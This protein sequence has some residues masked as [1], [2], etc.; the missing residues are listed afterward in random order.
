[1]L[2]RFSR[3]QALT[4]G[5]GAL[6][7]LSAT[8]RSTPVL[9]LSGDGDAVIANFTGGAAGVQD[10]RVVIELPKEVESGN[11]VALTVRVDSPMTEASRVSE[12]LVVARQNGSAKV[13]RYAFFLPNGVPEITT[14]VRLERPPA[15]TPSP[16][17]K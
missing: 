2:R 10:A 4:V 14:R 16:T 8:T 7:S 12:L 1:M 6:S 9:A 11:A 3:R 5:V 15:P 17:L 13:G